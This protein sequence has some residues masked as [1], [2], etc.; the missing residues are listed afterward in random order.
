M[1]EQGRDAAMTI[2]GHEILNGPGRAQRL[3]GLRK[4]ESIFRLDRLRFVG[5]EPVFIEKIYLPLAKFPD[6]SEADFIATDLFL[7]KIK[8]DYGMILGQVKVFLE[9]VLLLD[10]ECDTMLVKI[11]PAPGLLVER[12]THDETDMPIALT[13]RVFR[14]D[15][16]RHVLE[17]KSR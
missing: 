10:A 9:P 13:K 15:L 14:G 2:L 1:L 7:K 12:I 11:R 5:S 4:N 17:I 8:D 6:I 3:L 16:C